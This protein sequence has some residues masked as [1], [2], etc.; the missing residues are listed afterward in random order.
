[1]RGKRWHILLADDDKFDRYFFDLA[2]KQL[3]INTRLSPAEDGEKLMQILTSDSP[4]LPDVIFLD[5]NMPLKK[6]DEC[7]AEIKANKNL[8][9]IPVIIYSTSLHTEVADNLYR[10]GAHYYLKKCDFVK[11]PVTIQTILQ[12]LSDNPQ[13]PTRENFIA[14]GT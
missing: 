8:A 5:L 3:S 11:L 7:L 10:N 6:G 14:H 13:Q 4:D 9:Q 1:M 2:L 12:L